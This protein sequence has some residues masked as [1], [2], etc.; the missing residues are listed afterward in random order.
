[1]SLAESAPI[2][3]HIAG[4][5][6]RLPLEPSAGTTPRLSEPAQITPATT[7][8]S[9]KKRSQPHPLPRFIK[10]LHDGHAIGDVALTPKSQRY[11]ILD[12]PSSPT[13]G[14]SSSP[15]LSSPAGS[16]IFERDV[17]DSVILPTSPA[18]PSH[19][20]T[21]N[22]IPPVLNASSEAITDRHLDPDSPQHQSFD[23][24]A[25]EFS[26]SIK[27]LEMSPA[28]KP[29]GSPAGTLHGA[30]AGSEINVETMSQALRRTG[31]GDL[32]GSKSYPTSP[33]EGPGSR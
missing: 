21:E 7:D 32:S 22:H 23:Q 6:P 4:S 25:E 27:G 10:D 33:I 8:K 19:I 29:I 26:G 18:I 16:Q 5:T 1:M 20:Q 17:Q 24:W 2:S 28:R 3:A 13:R 12:L 15:R 14:L 9:S 11:V 30:S 31:S